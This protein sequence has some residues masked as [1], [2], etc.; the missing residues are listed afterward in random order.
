MMSPGSDWKSNQFQIAIK[1]DFK[2]LLPEF[3]LVDPGGNTLHIDYISKVI[4]IALLLN[5]FVPDEY[6]QKVS[7]SYPSAICQLRKNTMQY[8]ISIRRI[9]KE[10]YY[11]SY[12]NG[13]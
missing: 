6:L 11:L 10:G 13:G 5:E 7:K 1:G 9:R 4:F 12:S 2:V 8:G 3:E